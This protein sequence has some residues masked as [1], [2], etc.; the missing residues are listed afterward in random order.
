MSSGLRRARTGESNRQ[1]GKPPFF[2]TRLSSSSNPRW[3]ALLPLQRDGLRMFLDQLG[4]PPGVGLV[5]CLLHLGD[6]V[7]EPLPQCV[8]LD[9]PQRVFRVAATADLVGGLA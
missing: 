8:R 6:G 5:A 3:T 4:Q 9:R 2:F 1:S 7:E